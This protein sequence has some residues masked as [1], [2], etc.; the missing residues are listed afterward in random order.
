MVHHLFICIIQEN[1]VNE[2]DAI[3]D[4]LMEMMDSQ[5]KTM[6]PEDLG[7]QVDIDGMIVD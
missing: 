2:M 1:E 6:N 5:S 7:L 4:M 3:E